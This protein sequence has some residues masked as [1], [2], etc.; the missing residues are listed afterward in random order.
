MVYCLGACSRHLGL[1]MIQV[2]FY[3]Y[4]KLNNASWIQTVHR[5][6]RSDS[7][8]HSCSLRP[9]TDPLPYPRWPTNGFP[10]LTNKFREVWNPISTYPILTANLPNPF[11]IWNS[12]PSSQTRAKLLWRTLTCLKSVHWRFGCEILRVVEGQW[13]LGFVETQLKFVSSTCW[14]GMADV[15]KPGTW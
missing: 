3:S 15:T 7:V 11:W 10:I 6:V 2:Q 9:P 1:Y 8:G 5:T 13:L 4:T 12:P 14:Q